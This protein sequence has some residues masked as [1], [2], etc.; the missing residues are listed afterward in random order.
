MHSCPGNHRRR[1]GWGAVL[2][3]LEQKETEVRELWSWSGDLQKKIFFFF[4]LVVFLYLSFLVLCGGLILSEEAP[5]L[6]PFSCCV[7]I[8]Q[9]LWPPPNR[10]S[11]LGLNQHRAYPQVFVLYQK[12]L[13]YVPLRLFADIIFLLNHSMAASTLHN[14]VQE[15]W[16]A[17]HTGL[18]IRGEDLGERWSGN[19][20]KVFSQGLLGSA[21]EDAGAAWE[22]SLCL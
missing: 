4:L 5:G 22:Y 8:L 16:A 19:I 10:P 11:G 20:G 14:E 15:N 9:E 12:A 21:G 7:L 17:E 18:Q 2:I 3:W 6:T 13:L 1:W